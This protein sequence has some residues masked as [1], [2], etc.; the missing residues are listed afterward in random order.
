[1][2]WKLLICFI[3]NGFNNLLLIAFQCCS[4]RGRKRLLVYT[5]N[6]WYICYLGACECIHVTRPHRWASASDS[7]EVRKVPG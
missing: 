6:F 3:C 5:R 1:M 7:T 2:I 4:I